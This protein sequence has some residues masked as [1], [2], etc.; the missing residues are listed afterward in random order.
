ML[1]HGFSI[2][3]ALHGN[4]TADSMRVNGEAGVPQV[5]TNQTSVS[6]V[7]QV[8]KFSGDCL[9]EHFGFVRYR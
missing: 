4:E 1:D 2:L 6:H 5:S 7:R 8:D 3:G 9:V